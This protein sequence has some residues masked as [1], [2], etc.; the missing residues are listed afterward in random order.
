LAENPEPADFALRVPKAEIHLHL[1]GSVDLETLVRLARG[2]GERAGPE[3]TARLGLLYRHRDFP[4]FLRNFRDLCGEIRRPEDFA[5]I[6]ASLSDR[7]ERETVRYAEVFCSPVIFARTGMPPGEILEAVSGAA[8]RREVEG[9]PRLRFLLDGV[10]Q[11]GVGSLEEVITMA[12]D[13]RRHDVIG[14][15]L[16]GD[17]KALPTSA[18]AAAY[19]EARRLGLRTTVHAGEFDGARSV[20]EA[21]EVLE[22]E[23]VGHGVRSVEDRE[24]VR[25]LARSGI[26]LECCPTSNLRTG[27]VRSWKDHPIRA[28]HEAGVA[29]TVNSD[30]PAMFGTSLAGEWRVLEESVGMRRE[31]VLAIGRRTVRATFL[32]ENE[33]RI[34]DAEMTRA[35]AAAGVAS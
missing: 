19:R 21:V 16:G 4:H 29:V 12:G 6:T 33:K 7:L 27:V 17:E 30:D 26:P 31:E 9:G 25:M 15:G 22:V 20:W 32:P 14:I 1:E 35:A 11:F 2:R 10:R 8:R 3:L 23:R 34:L 28:L 18:F 5:V 24:L 13:F